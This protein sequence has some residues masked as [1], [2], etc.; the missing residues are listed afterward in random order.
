M[1]DPRKTEAAPTWTPPAPEAAG[2]P[3][4][5][6][7]ELV[8]GEPVRASRQ[9]APAR[10]SGSTPVLLA[11][12][13]IIAI[14]GLGFAVGHLTGSGGSGTATQDN[15]NG[16]PFG[17][18]FGPGASGRPD[19]AGGIGGGFT[20]TGTVVSVS[21]DSMVVKLADGSTTTIAIG[22]STTYHSQTSASSADVT[23]GDTVSVQ[24]SG[25]GPNGQVASASSSPS[26]T[27][28]TATDV[29]ITGQ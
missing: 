15:A 20:V 21:A 23:A 26:T 10:R 12:G 1:T 2:N 3:P 17:G 22:T 24:T 7:T 16:A 28:R 9:H 27:T 4:F 19:F 14:G 25:G 29:T 11:I 8:A 13:A 6:A 5:V 18:Q